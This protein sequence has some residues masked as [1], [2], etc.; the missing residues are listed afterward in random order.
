[1]PTV[2]YTPPLDMTKDG[3]LEHLAEVIAKGSSE[4]VIEGVRIEVER[5]GA[6]DDEINLAVDLGLK[7]LSENSFRQG[8][9]A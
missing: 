9:A 7:Q 8:N 6:N 4:G 2:T 3:M 1:M 5:I